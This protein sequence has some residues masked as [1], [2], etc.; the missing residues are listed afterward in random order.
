MSANYPSSS[1]MEV[2]AALAE[3]R[4][5]REAREVREK[6]EK[7]MP[8][9]ESLTALRDWARNDRAGATGAG[10]VPYT[11]ALEARSHGLAAVRAIRDTRPHEDL[12]TYLYAPEYIVREARL[13]FRA[14]MNA[15]GLGREL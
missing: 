1:Q 4:R 11:L 10:L 8:R 5:T 7:T 13:A 2:D 15:L 6:K 3:L 12:S 9:S 14:A